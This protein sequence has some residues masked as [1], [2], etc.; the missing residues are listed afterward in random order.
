MTVYDYDK[1][2]A[3]TPLNLATYYSVPM[4]YIAMLQQRET[5]E[6]DY[7]SAPPNVF[8]V[9]RNGAKAVFL[10]HVDMV[11][12]DGEGEEGISDET[13]LVDTAF[14]RTT[15]GQIVKSRTMKVGRRVFLAH[16]REK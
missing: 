7:D 5:W 16:R 12:F 11:I 6:R 2:I 14:K 3:Q 9:P 8:H 13:D 15:D 10:P 4:D 1:Y